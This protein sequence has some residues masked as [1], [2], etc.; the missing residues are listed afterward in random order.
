LKKLFPDS[1]PKDIIH[2]SNLQILTD[3][4]AHVQIANEIDSGSYFTICVTESEGTQKAYEAF[5]KWIRGI[6]DAEVEESESDALGKVFYASKRG[7]LIKIF[8]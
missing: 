4:T 8:R 6:P 3:G 1:V 7:H 5:G 2:A